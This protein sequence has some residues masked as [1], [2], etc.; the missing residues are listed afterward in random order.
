MVVKDSSCH[1]NLRKEGIVFIANHAQECD[2]ERLLQ[3]L[4]EQVGL[5]LQQFID[6]ILE[7]HEER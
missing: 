4:R 7:E 2:R 5:S 1:L 6:T 3:I